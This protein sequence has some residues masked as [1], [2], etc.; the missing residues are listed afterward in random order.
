[1]HRVALDLRQDDCPLTRASAAHDVTITTPHWRLEEAAGRWDLRVRVTAAGTSGE[2]E[3]ALRALRDA[4]EMRT[5]R[6]YAKR[7]GAAYV[8]T[9]FEETAAIDAVVRHGGYV[10]G[11]FHNA[12]GRERWRLGF[13]DERRA[14]AALAELDGHEPFSVRERQR[15]DPLGA[16]DANDGERG[17]AAAT[18][19]TE[20]LL[21]YHRSDAVRLL[22]DGG[23][24]TPTE[25]R[26]LGAAF[27]DG[28]F[29]SPRATTLADLG[30]RLGVS[31]V[32]VSETLRRAE[33]KLLGATLTRLDDFGE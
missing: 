23:A 7:D 13:D 4:D 10:V 16:A 20:A 29:E 15:I 11:P 14:D 9:V 17:P 24:L 19:E 8:R 5:F 28:Y 31:D 1:M 30:E 32:A 18:P 33:R 2:L 25:R 6:L 22:D 21:G 3:A 27:E 26:V 12:D